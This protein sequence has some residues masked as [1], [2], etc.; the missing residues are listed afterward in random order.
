M[1][2]LYGLT[3]AAKV[4]NEGLVAHLKLGGY[5]QS[6]WDQC[7]FYKRES[8]FSYVYF[9][10]HV[11][12]FLVSATKDSQL[13]AFYT[14]MDTKYELTSNDDGVFL[15][16]HMERFNDDSYIF[17][18]PNQLQAIFDTY[19]PILPTVHLPRDPMLDSYVKAFDCDDSKPSDARMFRSL[20]GAVMQ[21]TVVRPDIAFT[22]SKISQRQSSP[23]EKD[24]DALRYLVR[25]LYATRN[26]GLILRSSDHA[27]AA[28]LVKLRG[29]TDM[30]FAC[31][32]NGRSQYC[33]CFDLVAAAEHNDLHPLHKV[34]NTS[35][36][37]L[38][39][40]MAPTVDLNTVS[41]W[42]PQFMAPTGECGSLVELC[43]D[44]IFY[45]GILREI[46]QEQIEPT[47]LYG[48][49]DPMI[50]LATQYSGRNKRVRYMLPK[51][52][53]LMEQTKA[54]VFKLLRLGTTELPADAGTKNGHG[55]EF[56]RK[57][58]RVTGMSHGSA[59]EG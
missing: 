59:V 43:K 21:L 45:R 47:P 38:K 27:S 4:F 24:M 28:T 46:G 17:R 44:G 39:S 3:D 34:Y 30:S 25:Y 48:D 50:I 29:Y 20:L 22:V 23:R 35:M 33:D 5:I 11:D 16:I 36:F 14:H 12:D 32:G 2:N 56:R 52:N 19:L 42:H 9:K 58:D 51:I 40:F 26:R 54:Q 49:N 53:W 15:G 13:D 6:T 7:F 18:K 10:F 57:R 1:F 37:Y 55:T 8:M 41:S 31:H